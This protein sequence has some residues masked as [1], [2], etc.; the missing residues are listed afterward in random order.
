MKSILIQNSIFALLLLGS[1][2]VDNSR[3]QGQVTD[4]Q[5][6]QYLR[7]PIPYWKAPISKITHFCNL[8][9]LSILE[10]NS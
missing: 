3:I 8:Y 1:A 6:D 5:T 10:E 2:M 7:V 9:Y 4:S